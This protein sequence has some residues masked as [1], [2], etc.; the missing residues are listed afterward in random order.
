[1]NK[2]I[3]GIEDPDAKIDK[4]SVLK[5]IFDKVPIRHNDEL[6]ALLKELRNERSYKQLDLINSLYLLVLDN[7]IQNIAELDCVKIIID[8]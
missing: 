6:T 4:Y 7:V 2:N 8:R 3:V 5:W 1:M